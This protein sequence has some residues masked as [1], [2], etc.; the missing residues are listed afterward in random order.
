[1][2]MNEKKEKM[3]KIKKTIINEEYEFPKLFTNF[4]ER[5]YG[6]LYHWLCLNL[7]YLC[8]GVSFNV[9]AVYDGLGRL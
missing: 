6:I 9:P 1:M 8:G 2:V 4:V 7:I 5:D 3:E